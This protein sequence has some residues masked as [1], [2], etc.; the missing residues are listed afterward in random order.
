M[1]QER[2]QKILSLAGVASRRKA[3]EL[4]SSGKV[5]VNG[6][7]AIL[8][9]KADS[10][11]DTIMVEGKQIQ[12]QEEKIYLALN[13]PKGFMSSR[14]DPEGRKTIY[15]LFPVNIRNKLWSIGRLDY[16]TRGLIILTNDGELTQKLSHPSFEHEKEY[17]VLLN[18]APTPEQLQALAAGVEIDSGKTSKALVLYHPETKILNITIHE[19]KNRQ[20]RKMIEGV[21]LKVKDLNRV[22]IGKLK[23]PEIPLGQFIAIDIKDII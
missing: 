15:E 1:P 11:K 2:L 14:S 9:D 13:K 3:E 18:Q 10:Q 8:G 12:S 16:Q 5:M 19:G 23:L 7:V 21:G 22:R 17:E 6:K 20:V 4:I